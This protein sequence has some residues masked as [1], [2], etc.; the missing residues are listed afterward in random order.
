[1]SQSFADI[2]YTPSVRATQRHYG[3]HEASRYEPASRGNFADNFPGLSQR[4]AEF[5]AERDSFYL[6]SISET[7]WPYV[8]HRGGPT[9]FLKVINEKTI[10]F[11]DFSGNAQYVSVGN[12]RTNNRIAL[13]LM[14]YTNRH[15]LKLFG[16]AQIIDAADQ[17]DLIRQLNFSGMP[18]YRGK[19]ERAVL[20]T[21]QASD[22]NCQQH[23]TRRFSQQQVEEIV[24]P[25]LEEIRVLKSAL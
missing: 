12:L 9:G 15:R 13:I 20:I 4:E 7:D 22:W 6:S 3:S 16:T 2:A 24:A 5:I 14:D 18:G 23:I 17:P 25:L 8:Q 21:V 11:A 1:M 10:A 19:V